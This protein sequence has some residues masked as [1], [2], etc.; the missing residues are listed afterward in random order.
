MSECS[1]IMNAEDLYNAIL[2]QGGMKNTSV[3]TLEI[4]C[5]STR[6]EKRGKIPNISFY[7]SHY[8]DE[9]GITYN[10]YYGIGQGKHYKFNGK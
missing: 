5:A 10:E 9:G 6:I 1:Q 2:C 4:N 3:F 7:H 8:F